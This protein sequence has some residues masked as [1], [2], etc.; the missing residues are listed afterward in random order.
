MKGLGFRV[1]CNWFLSIGQNDGS[2]HCG[3]IGTQMLHLKSLVRTVSI[4]ALYSP[5]SD[6][7]DY[8]RGYDNLY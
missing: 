8:N 5:H 7:N 4:K 2:A 1:T 3:A 6:Y